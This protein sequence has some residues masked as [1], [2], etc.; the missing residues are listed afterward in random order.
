MAAAAAP[1]PYVNRYNYGALRNNEDH[2]RLEKRFESAKSR[3]PTDVKD[4]ILLFDKE[5]MPRVIS[6]K[7]AIETGEISTLSL[8]RAH[9]LQTAERK[10]RDAATD[11]D[12]LYNIFQ[13]N[14]AKNVQGL[15]ERVRRLQNEYDYF[16]KLNR[17]YQ[18]SANARYDYF[19]EFSTVAK[20]GLLFVSLIE[21]ALSYIAP[22][23][24]SRTYDFKEIEIQ[25]KISELLDKIF[26]VSHAEGHDFSIFLQLKENGSSVSTFQ[27]NKARTVWLTLQKYWTTEEHP[28][29]S[30]R[31]FTVESIYLMKQPSRSAFIFAKI[32][33][34]TYVENVSEELA[35]KAVQVAVEAFKGAK[36]CT[37][38][39][40]STDVKTAGLAHLDEGFTTLTN[41]SFSF[42]FVSYDAPLWAIQKKADGELYGLGTE[43]EKNLTKWKGLTPILDGK[44]PILPDF[45]YINP[46][47][48]KAEGTL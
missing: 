1:N 12:T 34:A 26:N 8:F 5:G 36:E 43:E 33:R 18:Q 46:Y 41:R 24:F 25:V 45:L 4:G 29:K 13:G 3:L 7:T 19:A 30:K 35:E 23:T 15:A 14:S 47:T 32:Q 21:A 9:F 6:I 22:A 37:H 10:V 28:T 40:L 27:K 44:T 16:N 38:L 31:F 20:L 39:F 17:A 11:I 48:I 2:T 42:P